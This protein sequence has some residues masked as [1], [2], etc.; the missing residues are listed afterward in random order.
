M[1]PRRKSFEGDPADVLF[2]DEVEPSTVATSARYPCARLLLDGGHSWAR[3]GARTPCRPSRTAPRSGSV[4]PPAILLPS[5][6]VITPDI[7]DAERLQGFP[8]G[9]DQTGGIRGP[10]LAQMVARRQCGHRVGRGMDRSASQGEPGNYDRDRDRPRLFARESGRHAA[11]YDGSTRYTVDVSSFPVW[12]GADCRLHEF[13]EHDGKPLSVRATR[14]LLQ[15]ETDASS[16][17]FVAGF[18][19]CVRAHMNEL[20]TPPPLQECL[21][22]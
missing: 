14:G 18:K 6:R 15:V 3:M 21:A 4:S 22:A 7:R 8:S 1:L 10:G 19:E 16:L 12:Q 11:R 17:R 5:G 20:E 13:L 9:M 2:V